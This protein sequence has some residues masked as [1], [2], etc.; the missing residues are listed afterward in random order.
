[1]WQPYLG[2]CDTLGRTRVWVW[3]FPGGT[4][5]KELPVNA[6]NLRDGGLI[7]RLGRSPGEGLAVHSSILAWRIPWTEEPGGL[8]SI[9]SQG[10]GCDL[11]CMHAWC[12]V[13][14]RVRKSSS[15]RTEQFCCCYFGWLL[16]FALLHFCVSNTCSLS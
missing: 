16:C 9:G 12:V 6:G 10:V 13:G 2:C 14:G 4:G 5:G 3:G 15:L 1:M 8:Q 7:P 11:A